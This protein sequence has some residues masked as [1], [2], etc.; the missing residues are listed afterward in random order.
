MKADLSV[1]I[2]TLEEQGEDKKIKDQMK[3]EK[4]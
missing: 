2:I 3:I 1:E 4:S